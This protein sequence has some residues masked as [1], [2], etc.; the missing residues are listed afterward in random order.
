MKEAGFLVHNGKM[1][2]AGIPLVSPDNRSFRYGDGFFETMKMVNGKIVLEELHMERLFASL[3]LLRFNRPGAFT[4]HYLREQIVELAARNKHLPL[5]RIRI[6]VFR[7]EGGLYDT[8]DH[9]PNHFIQTWDLN[10]ASNALNE[11][12]LV[13]GVYKEARKACDHFSHVKSN[14][15]LAY[16]MAA[17]WAKEQKLNDALLLNTYDRVADATIANLF[18]V[19]DGSVKTPALTEGCVAGVMRKHLLQS[20]RKENMP[21]E[22]TQ[23][24]IGEVMEA[25]EIFLTNAIHGIKWVKQLEENEFTSQLASSLHKQMILPLFV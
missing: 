19:K 2:K 20:L 14:N 12:G 23:L 9:Y 3:D 4:P 15:Y 5:A 16:A 6:T 11:N 21:V 22:E 25:S 24:T 10:P 18:I 13:L 17:L 7:G 1:R 8:Q